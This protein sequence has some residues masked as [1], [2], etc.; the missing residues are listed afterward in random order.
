M[1]AARRAGSGGADGGGDAASG[2]WSRIAVQ[3]LVEESPPGLANGTPAR[4]ALG[5]DEQQQQT[6]GPPAG[7]YAL[8]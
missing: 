1:L 4:C 8:R 2:R 5:L 7:N 6:H 3:W